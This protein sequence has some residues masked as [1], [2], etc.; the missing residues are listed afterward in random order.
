M[1]LWSRLPE[2]ILLGGQ[3]RRV[4]RLDALREP[5]DDI[6][7]GTQEAFGDLADSERLVA[8]LLQLRRRELFAG[9][10]GEEG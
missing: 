4:R 5:L 6:D 10:D 1:K 2:G 7:E 8:S 9:R 3:K